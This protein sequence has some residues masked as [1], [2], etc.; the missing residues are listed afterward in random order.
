PALHLREDECLTRADSQIGQKWVKVDPKPRVGGVNE[1]DV[2]PPPQP[3]EQEIVT[4][5]AWDDLIRFS[6]KRPIRKLDLTSNKPADSEM[7]ISSA[8]PL[9]ADQIALDVSVSG[10]LKGG[11][12]ASFEVTGVKLSS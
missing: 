9:G 12:T 10:E 8:Q 7:L 11:G 2:H 5:Q 6:E 4:V 3:P 1:P